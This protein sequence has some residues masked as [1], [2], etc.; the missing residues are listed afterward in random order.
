LKKINLFNIFERV[1]KEY[2][3]FEINSK[4]EEFKHIYD[5]MILNEII[6]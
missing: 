2:L 6:K 5:K 4:V 1:L 3:K